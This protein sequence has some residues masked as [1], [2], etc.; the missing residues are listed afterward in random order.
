MVQHSGLFFLNRFHKD[1]FLKHFKILIRCW[2]II[3]RFSEMR[4]LYWIWD[5]FNSL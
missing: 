1:R 4:S 2:I 3:V 5:L